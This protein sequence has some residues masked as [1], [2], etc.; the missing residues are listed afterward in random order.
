MRFVKRTPI[1]Q[2]DPMSNRFAVLA[3]DRI[4]TN[5]KISMEVPKGNQTTERPIVNVSGQVRYNTDIHEFEVYNGT[6]PGTGWE[7]VRTVRPAPIT[8]QD[9]GIGDYAKVL[10]GPLKWES[11]EDYTNYTSPQNIFV[12]VENVF[13]LPTLNYTLVQ[14]SGSQVSI[15]FTSP[16][17]NKRVYVFLG[18]DGYFP[19]FP[20]AST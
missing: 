19:E 16:V 17:P 12:Y 8:F 9:L 10:F 7:K 2:Y 20:A 5:T 11:G 3:D 18:Y 13:Q 14:G 1:T 4:V 6:S 15:Q